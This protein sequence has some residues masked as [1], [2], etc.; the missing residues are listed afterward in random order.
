MQMIKNPALFLLRSVSL[1][2]WSTCPDSNG[3]LLKTKYVIS[4]FI[5]YLC[6]CKYFPQALNCCWLNIS[7]LRT[8]ARVVSYEKEGWRCIS[9][10]GVILGIMLKQSQWHTTL[11]FIAAVE[12]LTDPAVSISSA[13]PITSFQINLGF[14]WDP[15]GFMGCFI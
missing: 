5:Y 10:L 11:L 8:E 3:T 13:V 9:V 4:L 7:L 15:L 12:K 6:W 2:I 1:G 14:S